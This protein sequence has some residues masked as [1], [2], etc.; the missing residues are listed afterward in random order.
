[1]HKNYL[2]TA[3]SLLFVVSSLQAQVRFLDP[4]FDAGSAE[5]VTYAN[6][7]SEQFQMNIDL[8]ADVYQPVGDTLDLR[9][10]VVLYH[11]GNFLPRYFNGSAYGGKD[12]SVNIEILTRLVERGYVGM[13][14]TY[15]S[16]W[17]PAADASTRTGTLLRAV[18]R[19]SQDGHAMARYLRKTVAEDDNPYRIDTSRIVFYGIGSGGYLVQAHNFLD[20]VAQ[21]E[22]NDQFYDEA[23]VSLINVDTISNPEGTI[24]AFEHIVNHPGYSSDVALTVNL[25]GAL[26]DSLWID[27]D[28]TSGNGGYEAPFIAAHSANDPFAP[29]YYGLVTVPVA[30]P[31]PVVRVPGSNLVVSLANE[32]GINDVLAPA[33]VATLPDMFGPL[34]NT[35]NSIVNDYKDDERPVPGS[36]TETFPLGRDNLWTINRTGANAGTNG[37]AGAVYNWFSEPILRQKI[38]GINDARPGANLDADRIIAGEPITNPNFNQPARAKAEIDSIM[39]HFYPRAWYALNLNDVVSSTQNLVST[40]AIALTIF[41]NPATDQFT[42]EV[43]ESELIRSVQITDIEGRIV[44]TISNINSNRTVVNREGMPRG[45]Y[46]V[47]LRLDRGVSAQKV[48]IR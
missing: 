12:D 44:R 3:L 33:N 16:G 37:T 42:V 5:T 43:A 13:S 40:T 48:F 24:A 10:V 6:N 38:T 47:Q 15:R 30:T 23:G 4:V 9:P 25:G 26:G 35:I 45:V 1:M 32:R 7:F 41:P 22:Q 28:K 29:F 2:I 20:D 46:I 11:T 27:G 14:A 17:Q 8:T 19:A 31:L 18:Y 36:N 21:V 39:A 34:A